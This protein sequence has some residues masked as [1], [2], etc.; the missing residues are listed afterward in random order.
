MHQHAGRA[1]REPGQIL[2]AEQIVAVEHQELVGA[3]VRLA[4]AQGVA[5][6]ARFDLRDRHPVAKALLAAQIV[7]HLL[8]QVVHHDDQA[9]D[10]GRQGP[11]DPVENR[12]ATHRQQRLGRVQRVRPE[13]CAQPGGQ[14]YRIHVVFLRSVYPD[15]YLDYAFFGFAKKMSRPAAS[16]DDDKKEY[17]AS[18]PFMRRRPK[19]R[20]RV[21]SPHP[22]DDPAI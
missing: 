22:A 19:D 11:S 5:G 8:G 4:A 13:S 9:I 2:R 7:F 21:H 1:G 17:Y 6:A 15:S 16:A 10:P 12:P 18:Q 3:N 14:Q 20:P